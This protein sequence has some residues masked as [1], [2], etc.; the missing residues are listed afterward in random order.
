MVTNSQ[1]SKTPLSPKGR[2]RREEILEAAGNILE[3][4]GYA[5]F[6]TRSI[7]AR[8]GIRLSN[9][10]YYFPTR[11]SLLEA[12]FHHALEAAAMEL[13]KPAQRGGL[14]PLIRFILADQQSPRSCRMFWELWAIAGREPEAY[15]VMSHYYIA[16]RDAL[17]TA[18]AM[19]APQLESDMLKKR[20]LLVMS[21]LEGVS[22]FRGER[23]KFSG[24][25]QGFDDDIIQAV[26]AL[27]LGA[28]SPTIPET[29]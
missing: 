19:E 28:A 29:S 7:A 26:Y 11:E 4:E 14:T 27:T 18:I 2:K 17:A 10:Q 23:R 22:L 3:E 25:G 5:G 1:T 16:Y 8:L 15:S 24:V 9:V 20:A 6:Y 12:L 21:L 13:E